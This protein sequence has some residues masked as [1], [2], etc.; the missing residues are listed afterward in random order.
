[1]ALDALPPI[2]G[3]DAEVAAIQRILAGEQ[4]LTIYKPIPVEAEKAAEVAVALAN[5]EDVGETTDFEGVAS[6]IFDPIVVTQ[7][8]VGDTVVADGFY[9]AA[10]I[11]TDEY[12]DAC[13]A[14]GL[15]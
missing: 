4:A 9:D 13:K 10:D 1:V 8:N 6:F 3:Q 14:A 15:S 11:C 5:G 12:A 2:T 7:D